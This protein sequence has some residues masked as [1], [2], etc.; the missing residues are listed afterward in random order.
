MFTK[1]L[2]SVCCVSLTEAA[3]VES[4]DQSRE[5]FITSADIM[6]LLKFTSHLNCTQFNDV[7]SCGTLND[8]PPEVL[9]LLFPIISLLLKAFACYAIEIMGPLVL[10][11]CTVRTQFVEPLG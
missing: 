9:R 7:T 6:C 10:K 8:T 5:Y 1:R 2:A 4:I 3:G 11:I